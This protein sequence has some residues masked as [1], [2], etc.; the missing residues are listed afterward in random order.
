GKATHLLDAA[1]RAL[2]LVA[3]AG[4]LQE[5]ALGQAA[6]L[7]GDPLLD[8]AQP[9]DRLRDR[10]EVGQHAAEPAVIDV[11]LAAAL[12]SVGDRLL[13]LALGADKQHA[14][15]AGDDLADGLEALPQ[16]GHGLLKVDDVDAVADAVYVR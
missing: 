9:L 8:L 7:G 5:F 12:G 14:A 13:R 10:L 16:Q 4:Q 3:V 11:I 2:E 15:S 6:L 1:E